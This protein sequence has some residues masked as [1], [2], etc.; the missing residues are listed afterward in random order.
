MRSGPLLSLESGPSSVVARSSR[1]LDLSAIP[2]SA[3]F[4]RS[5]AHRTR[6]NNKQPARIFV[7]ISFCCQLT[8]TM[9]KSASRYIGKELNQ[10]L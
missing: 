6:A 4:T 8:E 1:A 7:S 2:L 10:K 3:H 9:A 5:D